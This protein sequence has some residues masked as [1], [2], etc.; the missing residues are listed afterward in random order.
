MLRQLV[1]A[2]RTVAVYVWVSLFILICGPIGLLLAWLF[3]WP[4]VLYQFGLFA[5]RTALAIVGIRVV[6]E[7]EANILDRAAVYCVNHSSNVEPPLLYAVLHKV[8]PRLLILYKAELHKIPILSHGF[9]FVGF[10]PIE[11][12]NR[13]QSSKALDRAVERL[14]AG[15]SFLVFPEGTRSRTGEL[16]PFR[17]GA[18]VM[19]LRAQAPIVPVAIAGAREAMRKGSPFIFPVIVRVRFGPPVETAGLGPEQRDD[20]IQSVRGQV[21][22]M[23]QEIRRA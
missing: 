14:G 3:T 5:V 13:E 21:G 11:R 10:V 23:L 7:G 20:L 18:F 16:L 22:A 8:L 19:A 17:K 15:F 12:G 4:N 6:V 2:V 1:A 9:D